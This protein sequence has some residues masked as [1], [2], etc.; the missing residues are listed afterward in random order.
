[1]IYY[2]IAVQTKHTP[3]WRWMTTQLTSLHAVLTYLQIYRCPAYAQ[4]RIFFA[5]SVDALDDLLAAENRGDASF[6]ITPEHLLSTGQPQ[7]LAEGL[8]TAEA[9]AFAGERTLTTTASAGALSEPEVPDVPQAAGGITLLEARR[10]E[11]ELGA[12]GDQ[13]QPYQFAF[14]RS[15]PEVRAWMRLLAK[16]QRCDLEP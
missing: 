12:G 16:V 4:V 8:A 1:M 14:P 6:S 7:M 10:L 2:R 9:Q 11:L 3:I 13:D 5:S 15:L